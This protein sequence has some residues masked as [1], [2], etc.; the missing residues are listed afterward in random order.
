M[1][2]ETINRILIFRKGNGAS[3]VSFEEF[4]KFDNSWIK[5]FERKYR[6]TIGVKTI[7][8]IIKENCRKT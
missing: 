8:A 3:S 2:P 6:I 7:I 1:I 5:T 4:L